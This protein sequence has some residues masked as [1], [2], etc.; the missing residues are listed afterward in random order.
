M[1]GNRTAV[2]ARGHAS[3]SLVAGMVM[4]SIVIVG[5]AVAPLDT[6]WGAGGDVKEV[7]LDE[8][9]ANPVDEAPS[10]DAGGQAWQLELSKVRGSF[11][12]NRGQLA[13]DDVMYYAPG[14]GLSVYLGVGWFGYG[15]GSTD[16]GTA[17]LVRVSLDGAS[18]AVPVASGMLP[19]PT[20]F[21]L[22]DDPAG[23]HVGVPSF[24]EAVYSDAW[25]SI[26]LGFRFVE[27]YLKYDLVVH[28]GG[29]PGSILMTYEGVDWIGVDG[30]SGDLSIGTSAGAVRDSAPQGSQVIGG[31]VEPVEVEFVLRGMASVGFRAGP[32]DGMRELVIDPGIEYSTYLG[33]SSGDRLD[34]HKNIV[35][36]ED[37]GVVVSGQATSTDFPTS[38][39][40]YSTTNQGSTD[41]FVAK[42]DQDLS[43]LLFCTLFG[44]SDRDEPRAVSILTN[45]SII[46]G[47]LTSSS[48]LPVTS[49]AY[50][51]KL[52]GTYDGFLTGFNHNC[53]A[54]EFST[55]LGG[56]GSEGIWDM[57]LDD[58]GDVYI[59]A[60]SAS[61]DFPVSSTAFCS[62]HSGNT[63]MVAVKFSI[64]DQ[65]IVY[66]T[67]VGGSQI[68]AKFSILVQADGTVLLSG[69]TESMDFPTT[70]GANDTTYNGGRGDA[71]LLHL[72]ANGSSLVFSTLLGGSGYENVEDMVVD[73]AG[74]IWICGATDSA[75]LPIV[76]KAYQSSYGGGGAYPTGM[77]DAYLAKLSTDGSKVVHCSYFGG[78]QQDWAE[79]IVLDSRGNP[80][81]LGTTMSTTLAFP[82]AAIDPDY[83]GS[84]NKG[85]VAWMDTATGLLVNGTYLGGTANNL[86]GS[87]VW[88]ALGNLM[89]SGATWSN[90]FPTTSGCYQSSMEGSTDAV[91]IAIS[92]EATTGD[93]PSV[94]RNFM[95]MAEG[96]SIHL[97]WDVPLVPGPWPVKGYRIYRGT[98]IGD[99]TFYALVPPGTE[100]T[101]S[102]VEVGRYYYYRISA[103]SNSGE[104]PL[105]ASIGAIIYGPPEAPLNLTAVEG[106]KYVRLSWE[107]PASTGGQSILGYR[108][109]RGRTLPTMEGIDLP[110]AETTYLDDNLVNG[111]TYLYKVQAYTQ[112]GYGTFT[113]ILSAMPKGPPEAPLDL[114]VEVRDLSVELRWKPPADDGGS[115]I[116]GHHIFR[117]ASVTGLSL[118]QAVGNVQAWLDT[119]VTPGLTYYYAISAL[120]VL[121]E[122]PQCPPVSALAQ[123]PPGIPVGFSLTAGDGRVSLT[124]DHPVSD[125]G[126]PVK[127]YHILRGPDEGSLGLV[128]TV[129]FETAFNDT[130]VTNGQPYFYAVRAYSSVGPGP[131]TPVLRGVPLGLPEPPTGLVVQEGDG[132]A[133]LGWSDPYST[134][135]SPLTAFRVYRGDTA[136][137]LRT[138]GATGPG[139]RAF[140]DTGLVNGRTYY[141]AV[142]AVT[143]VGEGAQSDIGIARPFGAPGAPSGMSASFRDGSVDLAWQVPATDGGRMVVG[144]VVYRGADT[145]SMTPIARTGT[146]TSYTDGTVVLGTVYY[147][148]VTAR[149]EVGEG[150]R[151]TPVEI[152]PMV[153][154]HPPGPPTGLGGVSRGTTIGLIWGPPESDGGSPVTNYTVYRGLTLDDLQ[155][156]AVLGAVL[157]HDDAGLVV[158]TV[159][160]YC[161]AASNA[162]GEGQPS[163]VID[164]LAKAEEPPGPSLGG[165]WLPIV[166]TIVT[167]LAILGAVSL[168]EVGRYALVALMMPLLARLN[169]EDV[170]DNRV[171]YLIHGTIDENPGIHFN[172]L[173][174]QLELPNGS[175]V[176]HLE[177]L[178][179]EHFITSVR[180][181][182]L[183]R[184]YSTNSSIPDSHRMTPEQVRSGTLA[185]I[186]RRPGISQK[187]I[188]EELGVD[189]DTVGYHLRELVREGRITDSRSGKYV[190]YLIN[191]Q[192]LKEEARTMPGGAGQAW[193]EAD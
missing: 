146:T 184:F 40:A 138:I 159:Y 109:Y 145:G 110:G 104:G 168:T 73:E 181:G 142:A 99:E 29:S 166:L 42:L 10:G 43:T 93:G 14:T 118:V 172:A 59:A 105:S 182:R 46:I 136:M 179:R 77:G 50:D 87:M 5:Q 60:N 68:E 178:E 137:D 135:G 174:E 25:P 48:D 80:M 37:G 169:K 149:N 126:S 175:G 65:A 116:V 92:M 121:G 1:V 171:R 89:I 96:D 20:N 31:A 15:V 111:V 165:T 6:G 75:N 190:V 55:Y 144:Y 52:D 160:Y 101:D 133:S 120:N 84:G 102:S 53:S 162:A 13:M 100:Y 117:G 76:G 51:G 154:I 124:W 67:Y 129:G 125:G 183:K 97:T 155:P 141:Y 187:E 94:P 16:G 61:S 44:G 71:Y 33:G 88:D 106:N 74:D 18:G 112:E 24:A 113:G 157:Q 185:L 58:E 38:G 35:L 150:P 26:D 156:V 32:Y 78:N 91:M 177:V 139:T 3:W 41:A 192:V 193:E 158:G 39:D 148:S 131:T 108:L 83:T 107:A 143:Q 70:P 36:A 167:V 81:I 56:S 72:D 170:L 69:T 8:G 7:R 164:V 63:D 28:P 86:W 2:G 49:G 66:G 45:G 115:S 82:S 152:K 189:R 12:E 163:V 57:A 64:D 62:T 9:R 54:L 17:R 103:Y 132:S 173:L 176:Y 4:A 122:G 134:G 47:G 151:A 180:D 114:T 140:A 147:Y 161:V 119:N 90:D 95:A 79:S 186:A 130:G 98:S 30:S 27:G 22:G 153:P 128:A 188:I 19:H 127:G 23:W 34:S 21:L 191:G 85:F 11:I 123:G